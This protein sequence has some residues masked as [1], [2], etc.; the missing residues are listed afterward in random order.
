MTSVSSY[1]LV[2][3]ALAVL[4]GYVSVLSTGPVAANLR[5]TQLQPEN[6]TFWYSIIAAS[7]AL[8]AA[9]GYVYFG[10]LSNS[11]RVRK[12]SRQ[13]IFIAAVVVLA[14]DSFLLS[15][16]V[17]VESLLAFWCVLT[18][19]S[20]AVL[21]T[22]TA[23]VLELL[24]AKKVGI[25]SGLFGAGAVFALLYGV[26]VG[27][28]THNN[29]TLVISIGTITA[30]VLALPATFLRESSQAVLTS[31]PAKFR[32]TK[33]F[34]LFL[35][36]TF[37]AMAALAVFNDYF[38]QIAKRLDGTNLA[39]AASNA[40]ALI[41]FSSVA[42][43]LGSI[44]GGIF[45]STGARARITFAGSVLLTALAL[46]GC[47]F[48]SD[49]N[50]VAI[51]AVIGGLAAGANLG[52]QLPLMKAALGDKALLGLESGTFNMVSTLPSFVMPAIGAV[53][54]SRSPDNWI[55]YMALIVLALAIAGAALARMIRIR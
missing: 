45:S 36:G 20:S 26:L 8:A 7:G 28:L 13:S 27:T 1:R 5:V 17:T 19:S 22:A 23:I 46:L 47:S 18:L 35:I 14:I 2:A 16:A 25:A 50:L 29:P 15:T 53:L 3:L 54:V 30:V 48:A 24:P 52:S 31:S 21:S 33:S 55:V 40:Q 51:G 34:A 11:L 43:L 9:L 41:G 4:A 10:K 49:F 42:V 12:G 38:Y 32:S 37:A 6:S 39:Q 44:A